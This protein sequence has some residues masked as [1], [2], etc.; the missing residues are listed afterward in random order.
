MSITSEALV[1]AIFLGV[2]AAVGVR[3]ALSLHDIEKSV[4][5]VAAALERLAGRGSSKGRGEARSSSA[6]PS[7][8]EPSEAEIAAAIAAAARFGRSRGGEE[9]KGS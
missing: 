7:E 8:N 5:R 1:I 6:E 3:V 4:D 2:L 9:G